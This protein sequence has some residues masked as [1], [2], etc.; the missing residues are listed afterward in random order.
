[1][2]YFIEHYKELLAIISGLSGL[3]ALII[4]FYS[5]YRDSNIRDKEIELR[6][7]QISIDKKYQISKETYQKLFEQKINVY[8]KLYI[9]INKFRKQLYDVGRYF[10]VDDGYGRPTMEQL[11]VEDV[12]VSTLRNIFKTVQKNHFVVSNELMKSYM[13]LYDLYRNHTADFDFMLDVGDYGNPD[14]TKAEWEKVQTRFYEKYKKSIDDFFNQ[15]DIEIIEMKK[16]L[17]Y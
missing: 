8:E 12:S 5:K 13:N 15:I 3:I 6:K 17:E 11:T 10:D 14:E 4:T 16:V 1:M 9:E 2:D 7:E